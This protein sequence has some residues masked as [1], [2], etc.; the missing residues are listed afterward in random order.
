MSSTPSTSAS[1][2]EVNP[3]ARGGLR[4]SPSRTGARKESEAVAEETSDSNVHV[5]PA[6]QPESQERA[7]EIIKPS[8]TAV[9]EQLDA[10]IEFAQEKSNISK[11]LKANLLKLRKAVNVAKRDQEALIVRLE[12]GGKSEK[13]SQTEPFIF[14]TDKKQ[15]AV[16]YALRLTI[17][18]N[19]QRRK[20]A[21]DSPGS[22]RL[23]PKAKRSK[24]HGGID[25]AKER[26]EGLNP[27]LGTRTPDPS[28]VSEP[29]ENPW[30]KVAKKKKVPKEA[31]PIPVRKARDKGEALLVKADKEKYADVLKAMR[32]EA[33][34]AE[35][36]KEVRSIRRTKTGEMLLE[37]KK[38]AQGGTELVALAQQ[39]LGDTAEVRALRNEV[40]LQCKRLDEIATAEELAMAIKEQGGVDVSR[41]S[42]RM[43]KGPQGTQIA[44]FKLSATDANKVL[45][46][47]RLK[48]GWSVCPVTAYQPPVV[49]MC[50]RCFE[51]GHKSWNCKGP[52]RSNL[53]KRCGGEGHKAYAC[54][55]TPRCMLCASK[56]KATNHVMG[57]PTC[58]TSGGSKTA[59]K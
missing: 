49:D 58:S 50:F 1:S 30:V 34:L 43:R 55:R 46:V 20:R 48:V 45:K 15:E 8:M 40:A 25:G 26:G 32:S 18:R 21:R 57:G 53:C 42:I 24:D 19:K 38:G 17:E 56:K 4:R 2:E 11:E 59:C 5:K 35:L 52:D 41:E 16:D 37:L 44:T 28:H 3:F 33:K 54:E 39:V 36:G 27:N 9:I 13:C 31:G 7:K 6:N 23:T 47:G 51:P 22:K 29:G 12:G 10:I 14:D